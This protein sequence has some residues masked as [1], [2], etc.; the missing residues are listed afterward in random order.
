M[1][2]VDVGL[3][4]G[5]TKAAVLAATPD[6]TRVVDTTVAAEGWS[7]EP[8]P[9]GVA[10]VRRLLERALPAGLEPRA[11]GIGAQGLDTAEIAEEFAAAL[12]AAGIRA[13]CVND[14]ALLVP[15]AGLETGIGVIAGTGAIGVST[16][17]DG[18]PLITGGWGWIIGDEAGSAGIVREATRAALLAHDDGEPDDGLLAALL[19]AFGVADAERLARAVNDEATMDNWG[20]AAPAVFA[21]AD[22]GSAGAARV[23][24]DAARHL[25]RLVDQL[26]RRG[27]VG[28][29]V[30]AAGSVIVNQPR[31]ADGL[32]RIVG[33]RHP[34][35]RVRLLTEPPVVGAL[36]IARRLAS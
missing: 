20:P 4:L 11:V 14:A 35:F 33:E 32:A 29:D 36:A 24:D 13:R 22:A 27:A 23:V 6:G 10:W 12:G 28:S 17:A 9:H 2:A 16:A 34:A 8:I 26:V 18:R 5:G 1:T 7:A 31:L 21:A 15:A 19:G 30:V 3:D 25:A